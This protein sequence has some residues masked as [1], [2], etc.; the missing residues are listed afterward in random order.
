MH[1]SSVVTQVHMAKTALLSY[2]LL[3]SSGHCSSGTCLLQF[4]Y[5]IIESFRLEKTF[6]IIDSTRNT[7]DPGHR[8]PEADSIWEAHV[9]LRA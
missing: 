6:K 8:A 2:A 1:K 5:R 4:A 7:H 9:R 3:R